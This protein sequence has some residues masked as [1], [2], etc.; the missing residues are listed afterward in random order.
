MDTR[1]VLALGAALALSLPSYATTIG[2]DDLVVND[3]GDHVV[4]DGY[5]GF[6][7]TGFFVTNSTLWPGS[8]YPNAATSPPNVAFTAGNDGSS[9]SILGIGGAT[10]T[11]VDAN[12]TAAWRDGLDVNVTGLRNGVV[13][14]S[15][16]LTVGTSAPSATAFNWTGIDT[17]TFTVSGGS[18]PIGS[19]FGQ[20]R[21]LAIDDIVIET[22]V[23]EPRSSALLAAGLALLGAI[24]IRRRMAGS[25]R[26][27]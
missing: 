14:D 26:P 22:A 8:G 27:V 5:A 9:A 25:R 1:S 4:P 20:C 18:A 19:C 7:W 15:L 10:F 24:G 6:D 11:F 17:V 3:L 13:I 2:F 16:G 21:N 12:L 23:P